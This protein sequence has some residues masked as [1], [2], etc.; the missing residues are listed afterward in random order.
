MAASLAE[1]HR[2]LTI[3]E[4]DRAWRA[5]VYGPDE[6]LELIEGEVFHKMSP[7]ESE[8]CTAVRAV[9]EELRSVFGANHDVRVQMPLEFAPRSKP[10]P[11]VA[12]VVGNFRDYKKKQP[13]TS[14]LVV[15]VADTTLRRDRN[16]KASL[17]AKAAIKEYWIVVLRDRV[18]E[19]YREPAPMRES[20]SGHG[21][22]NVKRYEATDVISPLATPN[23]SINIADLLP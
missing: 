21:Y 19:V 16:I 8:H 5:G 2:L 4:F 20:R 17:Y 22:L 12:V 10:E 3:E 18:L 1:A 6:K 23:S 11:D 7:Q 14:V 13:T 9:E 15:E